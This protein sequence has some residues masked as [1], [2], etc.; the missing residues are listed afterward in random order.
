MSSQDEQQENRVAAVVLIAAVLMAVG[1]AIG[2]AIQKVRGSGAKAAPAAVAAATAGGASAG[3]ANGAAA[4]APASAAPEAAAPAAASDDASV[5][6]ENGVVKFYFASGKSDLAP[7]AVEA[8]ADAIAA[9]KAGQKLVISG[10]HDSTGDP[11]KNA[12]LA[13]QRALAVRDALKAAGVADSGIELKKPET[14]T[15]SG[16]NAE[17]R[18]VEVMIAS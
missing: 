15:G 11:A 9:G 5:V 10:F 16:N 8:L 14:A 18:R 4:S 12:E 13:K 6:V 7:G 1:L 17:A 3:T 2:V